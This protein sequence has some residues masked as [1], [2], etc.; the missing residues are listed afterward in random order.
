[1]LMMGTCLLHAFLVS[2]LFGRNTALE[3]L[4]HFVLCHLLLVA[5]CCSSGLLLHDDIPLGNK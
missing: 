4:P 2:V 1:M 3:R 5:L